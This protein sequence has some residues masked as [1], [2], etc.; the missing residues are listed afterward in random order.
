L[1]TQRPITADS[2]FYL[3]STSKQFT[4][5]GLARAA[6]LQ[7]DLLFQGSTVKADGEVGVDAWRDLP[8]FLEEAA[9]AHAS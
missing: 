6:G 4:A 8:A 3:A 7:D 2:S 5:M 9:K 1:E